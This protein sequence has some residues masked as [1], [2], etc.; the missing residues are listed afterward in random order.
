MSNRKN[1]KK[2]TSQWKNERKDEQTINDG[3]YDKQRRI[4]MNRNFVHNLIKIKLQTFSCD[5]SWIS[6]LES[7]KFSLTLKFSLSAFS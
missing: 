5:G 4:V 2:K 7:D 6:D 3:Y 1:R